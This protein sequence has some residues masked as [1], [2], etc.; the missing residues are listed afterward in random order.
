MDNILLFLDGKKA[1][2][3]TALGAI[4]AYLMATGVYDT[5][6]GALIASLILILTGVGV[7]I[8]KSA[9]ANN[10]EL[11]TAILAKRNK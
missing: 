2:I 8:T 3:G 6:L 10:T 11:G 7:G 5:N 4:N 1:V 9:I